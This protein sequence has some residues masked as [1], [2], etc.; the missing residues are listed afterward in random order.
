MAIE[1]HDSLSKHNHNVIGEL[2]EGSGFATNL[3]WS[4]KSPC[5][6]P[7]CLGALTSVKRGAIPW[8]VAY[9][10]EEQ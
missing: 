7:L 6:L 10:F 8:R 4:G 1:F 5:G 9:V 3:S 2:L